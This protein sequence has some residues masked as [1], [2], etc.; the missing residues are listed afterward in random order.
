[1]IWTSTESNMEF[2]RLDLL[3][4][5]SIYDISIVFSREERR[6]DRRLRKAKRSEYRFDA[7]LFQIKIFYLVWL[8]G[9]ADAKK[10]TAQ[11]LFPSH[12]GRILKI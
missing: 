12:Q 7:A 8:G 11:L 10:T 9:L 5:P 1:M 3:S 4:K 2:S 6:E